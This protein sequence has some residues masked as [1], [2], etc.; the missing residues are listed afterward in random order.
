MSSSKEVLIS[1][2]DPKLLKER[3]LKNYFERVRK[4]VKNKYLL[5]PIVVLI[6][7]SLLGIGSYFLTYKLLEEFFLRNGV[8][9]VLRY[10][11]LS[12]ITA[13][14]K[15]KAEAEKLR[16]VLEGT[17]HLEKVSLKKEN[18]D[19]PFSVRKKLTFPD[20]KLWITISLNEKVIEEKASKLAKEVAIPLT[21]IMTLVLT[22]YFLTLKGVYLRLTNGETL[23]G[24]AQAGEELEKVKK[25]FNSIITSI[26][27]V[28]EESERGEI[29]SDFIKL[30][31][32]E[33]GFSQNFVKVIRKVLKT[34]GS[35]G[36]ILG[37]LNRSSVKEY[38]ITQRELEIE[39]K[40]KEE[41]SELEKSILKNQGK[42]E[43]AEETLIPQEY[44]KLGINYLVGIPLTIH[45]ENLG[46]ALFFKRKAQALSKEDRKLIESAGKTITIALK[47]ERLADTLNEKSRKEEELTK[48]ILRSLIRG[49]EI[50]DSYTRG[51]SE[52]VAY[53]SKRIAQEMGLSKEKVEK[54]YLGALLHDIGKI[55][56]PD[57]I[58]LKP[59]KLD[60]REYRILKLHPILSYE[61]LK[62]LDFLKGALNGIKYHHER[63]D[64]SGYP[65]GLKGE[66][67]PVEARIIAVADTFDAMTSDRIYRKKL[68]KE[69]AIKE[70]KELSGKAFD[71][72]VVESALKVFLKEE[73]P[74]WEKDYLTEEIV[75]ETEERRLDYF[76]RDSLTGVFNRNALPVAYKIATERFKEVGG[77][78]FDIDKLRKINI[79]R[80]WG[81]GDEVIKEVILRIQRKLPQGVLVRYSGDN[82][83]IFVEKGKAEEA[84]KRIGKVGRELKVKLKGRKIEVNDIE[85]L[86]KTLTRIEFEGKLPPL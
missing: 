50:R 4:K 28:K 1:I 64:G 24:I 56:I 67:I 43:I 7:A 12:A 85:K 65:E 16:E 61:L 30:L 11:E 33:K 8:N 76:L 73:P 41:L 52:R 54:I 14:S 44:K 46:F 84:L 23:A 42:T 26:V 80:G 63:W 51:H 60:E 66:Q 83:L 78:V 70:I 48:S 82:F 77:I 37:I 32:A 13:S 22:L 38:V 20:G 39:V 45:S 18:K 6:T 53:F 31:T 62:N 68:G 47:L 71:P 19:S 5:L 3:G 59:G 86:R 36:V 74:S 79:K 25:N 29:I 72:E 2:K 10:A 15:S 21:L 35:D 69:K 75:S 58:L 55:G 40:K 49:I 9:S 34:T 57:S 17:Q 27:K 81:K